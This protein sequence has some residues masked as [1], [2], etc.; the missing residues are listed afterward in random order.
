MLPLSDIV[1]TRRFSIVDTALLTHAARVR[2]TLGPTGMRAP[3]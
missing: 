2:P 1:Q 3:A